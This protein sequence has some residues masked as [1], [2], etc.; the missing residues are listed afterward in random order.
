MS[1]RN[2]D[3]Y[4][5]LSPFPVFPSFPPRNY[6]FKQLFETVHKHTSWACRPLQ[7]RNS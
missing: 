2:L 3:S 6:S 1:Q 7:A 5:N 4:F